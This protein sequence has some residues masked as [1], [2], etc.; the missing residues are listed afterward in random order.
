MCERTER[1]YRIAAVL[2]CCA[3]LWAAGPLRAAPGTQAKAILDAAG[4]K[5]GLVVHVGCGDGKL[6]AALRASDSYVV[7]GLDA[8]AANVAAARRHL[9]KL[10][11]CGPVSVDRL[12]GGHLPY[13]DNLVKLLVSEGLGPVG[14][15]EVLR[16]LAPGGVAYVRSGGKWARTVK[17]RPANIDEW[18]HYLHDATGNAVAD[19]T[20]VGPPRHMQWLA[21][22]LWARNHHTLASLSAMISANGRVFCIIDEGP[23]AAIAVPARWSLAARDAFSGVLLWKKPVKSWA[24]HRQRFRSGPVQLPRTLVADD[25][26][27]YAPLGIDAPVTA[28]D[29]ATGRITRTYAGTENTEEIVLAGGRLLVVVGSPAAEQASVGPKGAARPKYPNRKTIVAMKAATGEKLWQWA[30]PAGGPLVPLTLAATGGRVFFQSGPGVVCLDA[31]TGKQQWRSGPDPAKADAQPAD[32]AAAR[33]SAR[34]GKG[35]KKRRGGRLRGPGW[36]VATLV[37]RDGVVL[38]AGGGKLS[39]RA[40][41][42]GKPLWQCPCKPGFRSPSDVFVVGSLV[43]L[44][45]VFDQGRDLHTGEVKKTVEALTALRTAGHHHRCYREKA[46]SRY[47]LSGHRGVEMLD[48]AGDNHSRNNWVR[49]GCQYGVMPCN[50]LLYTPP[51]ACGCYMESKLYGFW[52]VAAKRSPARAP[53]GSRLE[54]GE[55]YGEAAD[56]RSQISNRKSQISNSQS[57]I[58]NAESNIS[59]PQS[60]IRNPQSKGWPTYRHDALR[61]GSTT[62]PAPAKL[63]DRWRANVGGKL[64]APVVA[65]GMVLVAVTDEHRV[66]ALDAVDGKV[67]W[68]F[69]ADGRVD[70]PPTVHDGRVLFGCADGRVYCLRADDGQLAWRFLAAPADLRTV[71]RDQVESVWPVHGSVLVLDGVAYAAAGR[72]SYLDDGLVL[73]ALDPATG[74]KL[75]ERRIR[76]QHPKGIEGSSA[77]KRQ[78]IAQNAVDSK[79]FKAPDRSDAF[80][81]AGTRNDVLVSDGES[82]YLRHLRFDRHCTPQAAMGRH[83]FSTSCLL[84]GHENHRSHWV[85]GTGDFSRTPVAYSWIVY[86]VNRWPWRLSVPHGLMLTFDESGVWGVRRP[87]PGQYMLYAQPNRPFDT[88]EKPLPDFRKTDQKAP[89][90]YT[91]SV[92]L[93][94]RTR[95]MVRAGERLL[96]GGTPGLGETQESYPAYEGF[97]HGLLWVFS[98]KDGRKLDGRKLDAPPVWDGLAVTGGRA[99]LATTDGRVT[100]LG[101]K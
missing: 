9:R 26:C 38:S 94:L 54:R 35:T 67:R 10:G 68:E 6:T 101:G 87:R 95:A 64:T 62:E 50:G 41:K 24:S 48:L 11:L 75:S 30:K 84:D 97:Q 18:T 90:K 99:Y 17:P 36:S 31:A 66:V 100:C 57:Q 77:E 47:V 78:N 63:T 58:S 34:K 88:D 80:S 44:G 16:V 93:E 4:V 15:P 55:A 37:V 39:A 71:A 92:N 76:G 91:W 14:M 27:A 29:A 73:Y 98:T 51:H 79:T 85:L 1:R 8:D 72:C 52:A 13:T 53:Q 28:L 86:N 96:L 32:P 69:V 89:V 45:P 2:A 19:D 59:S 74:R 70:S 65:D 82:V 42:T 12:V 20:V 61:S 25:R 83:L 5:G 49:G 21:D 46:T 23:S 56:L 22:P 7:H 43:W 33:R 40:A 81:M 60:A 3:V